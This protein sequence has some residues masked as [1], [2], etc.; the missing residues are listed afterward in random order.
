MI[1]LKATFYIKVCKKKKR[2][3]SSLASVHMKKE[4]DEIDNN[5]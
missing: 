2:T 4:S 5:D 1:F 3:I